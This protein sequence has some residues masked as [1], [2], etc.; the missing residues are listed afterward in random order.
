VVEC[1][2]GPRVERFERGGRP[3]RVE[4]DPHAREPIRLVADGEA[5]AVGRFVPDDSKAVLVQQLRGALAAGQ[6]A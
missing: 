3:V 6:W 4:Y 1:G 2:H 5:I